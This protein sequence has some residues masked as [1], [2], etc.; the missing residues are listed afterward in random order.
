[1]LYSLMLNE[2]IM[3]RTNNCNVQNNINMYSVD[4]DGRKI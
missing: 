3:G 2:D 1:M 4:M